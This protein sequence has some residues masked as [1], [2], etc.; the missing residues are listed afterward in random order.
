[1]VFWD[2]RKR[3]SWKIMKSMT[4]LK[5]EM[6]SWNRGWL[7]WS[8]RNRSDHLKHDQDQT[9]HHETCMNHEIGDLVTKTRLKLEYDSIYQTWLPNISL[10]L[11]NIVSQSCI[12]SQQNVVVNQW[13][14]THSF[15]P[16]FCK[17]WIVLKLEFTSG[18][19][20]VLDHLKNIK[21]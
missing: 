16:T 12:S 20:L 10:V 4:S 1:M 9:W 6:R 13:I 17:L 18:L 14:C 2:R 19:V 11:S 15:F 3:T 7:P 21:S 5:H 8:R